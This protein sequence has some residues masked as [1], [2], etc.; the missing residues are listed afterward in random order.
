[1]NIILVLIPVTLLIGLVGLLLFFLALS[2]EQF[3]DLDTPGILILFDDDDEL[4]P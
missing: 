4:I 2:S 1:M 3:E